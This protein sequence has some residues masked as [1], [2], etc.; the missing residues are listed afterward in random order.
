MIGR[1]SAAVLCTILLLATTPAY[2]SGGET[3]SEKIGRWTFSMNEPGPDMKKIGA[4]RLKTLRGNLQEITRLITSAPALTPPKGF[5][6][7]FWGTAG[8]RDRYDIC[9]G[10]KCPSSRPN[11]VLSL[12]I[13]SYT[14]MNGKV[15]A[16]FNKT[17]TMDIGVNNLGHVFAHLP[18]LYKDS[19]GLLLPEPQRDGERQGI[20]AYLNNGHAIA[21]LFRNNDPLWL[22]VSRE[23]YLTAAIASLGTKL[24]QSQE[25]AK[26]G[27]R[28]SAAETVTGKHIL[29]EEGRTWID[30][31]T[32]KEWVESSRTIISDMGESA[33]I[34]GE[35][36]RKLQEE[37]ASLT[38]EQRLQQ[39]RIDM[40][41]PAEGKPPELLPI[42]SSSGVGVVTPNFAFF[43]RKLPAD[44]VQ[45]IT[46]QWKFDGTPVFDPD[47]AG[48]S[49][50]L[51]NSKLLDIY[52]SVEW[53]KLADRL[54]LR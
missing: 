46:L 14:E 3:P 47:K 7:R 1:T 41:A 24:G 35:R 33:E 44:S 34:L 2:A 36:L 8:S 19:D 54:Q 13:G 50:N 40:T 10:K 53:R 37:L 17:A 52:R 25:T 4:A 5:E 49:E 16:A 18:V 42:D 39:A 21:V 38:P 26:K 28:T 20:P 45:L 29:L 23:R 22:P 27:G 11:G 15:K 6:A 32:E 12:M 43:N 30:P 51:H 9:S 31:A 48:I